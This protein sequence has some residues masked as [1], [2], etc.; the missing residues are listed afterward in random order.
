VVEPTG[1]YQAPPA[2]AKY[3]LGQR[4]LAKICGRP[5]TSG[6]VAVSETVTMFP[7]FAL[8]TQCAPTASCEVPSVPVA[9]YVHPFPLGIEPNV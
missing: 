6:L 8:G 2:N 5:V 3:P 9:A 1:W 4:A 7:S